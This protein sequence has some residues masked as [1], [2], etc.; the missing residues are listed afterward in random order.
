MQGPFAAGNNTWGA[1]GQI[2]SQIMTVNPATFPN[3]TSWTW[4]WPT[5][6]QGKG[7]SCCAVDSFYA[8]YWGMSGMAASAGPGAP[9][10]T[11][12][13]AIKTLTT[14][15][16]I[17]YKDSPL[18]VSPQYG[19]WNGN[20]D[21]IFDIFL[22]GYP[23]ISVKYEPLF[24]IEISLRDSFPQEFG[25]LKHYQISENG[26]TWTGYQWPSTVKGGWN[27]WWFTAGGGP[28]SG[29]IDLNAIL[30][31]LV[32][33]GYAT[34]NEWFVGIPLGAEV[35]CG[36]GGLTIHNIRLRW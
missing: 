18:C 1:N 28:L 4:T 22:F 23:D 36:T 2:H 10:A 17:S 12:L 11:Q 35:A 26:R 19:I 32:A 5:P 16:N 30:Q 33:H 24:E 20:F 14:T 6:S 13:K 7:I 3:G 34:G 31:S 8:L 25:D 9:R 27:R 15:F 29:T 21:V